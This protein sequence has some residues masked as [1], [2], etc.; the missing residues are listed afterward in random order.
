M[1][2]EIPAG[3]LSEEELRE[4][5]PQLQQITDKYKRKELIQKALFQISELASSVSELPRLYSAL[6]E[7]I[8]GFMDA[9]NFYVAFYDE[10]SDLVDI[11]YF[12][13][14][15]DELTVNEIPASQLKKGFTG[16]VLTTGEPLFLTKEN[17]E[18]K[19]RQVGA[20]D[21]GT[22]SVDWLG[23]PLKRGSKCIGAMVV[24][25][26]DESVRYSEED[27]EVLQF[28]SQHI[29][30]SVDRVK[31][32]ELTERTIRERTK[33]LRQIND[34]LQE[35]IQ[36]R[37]K[38]EDL[39]QALFEI[40]EL[41]ASVDGDME[42]FY[43]N[44]HMILARLVHAPNCYIAT[45]D[46]NK[47]MLNFP[48]FYD[49]NNASAESRPLG[50]GL[51]E[52]V[53]RHGRAELIGPVR[54]T[55]LADAGEL[56]RDVA[57]R[58]EKE[59]NYWVGTPLVVDG[60]V[61]GV[62]GIQ[63]YDDKYKYQPRDL[64]LLRYISHHIAVALERKHAQ[65]SIQAYNL[66]LA[67]KVKERTDE[68]HRANASLKEQIEERKHIELKLIHDAHHDTLTG[69]P[70]RALF[71]SRVE[72]AIANKKRYPKNKF[73]VLFIDLDRFKLINDTLGHQA[74]DK[75]LIEVS[76]RIAR[77]IR[78]HDLLARLG[79]DEFVILLDNFDNE[80]DAEEVASRILEAMSEA[81]CLDSTEMYSGG[82]IGIAFIEPWY[83]NAGELIRD[84]DAA[85]YQAKSMGRGRYVMFDQSMR[86]RL[87]EELEL[88]NEF[89]RTLKTRSFDC[90]FQPIVDM[91]T[92]KPI[93]LECYVRWQHSTLGKIKR[94]QFWRVAEHIGMTM[95]IDRFMIERACQMLRVWKDAGGEERN[96]RV[97]INL[98]INHLIQAKQVSQL[99]ERI[100]DAGIDPEKLVL[101]IDETHINRKSQQVLAA[102]QQLKEAGVTLVLDNFGNGMASLNSLCTFP[103]DYVKIDRKFVRS[104]P[105]SIENLKIIQSV[106][107]ISEHFGFE[108]IANG[109]E[110][111]EQCKALIAANC[112]FGQ[113][114]FLAEA[115]HLPVESE[116]YD[117]AEFIPASA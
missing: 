93:Y 98:S 87:L 85:M 5:V 7:I 112:R 43:A 101:E 2:T 75:F 4:L 105:A 90:Y 84:A 116:A 48:Y 66:H 67:E 36:E 117:D 109:I 9:K 13:D 47:G 22:T 59:R 97:A 28:V 102:V 62:V 64:E 81:F 18:D 110:N 49:E 40:S 46:Q 45:L 31:N 58:M 53:L 104:L 26:Y 44:L 42:N 25:S 114:K 74:G 107:Q 69:L 91:A 103:F 113:G 68:L 92:N 54:A 14:E 94:E 39:Q 51:T 38:I 77:C 70:N 15:F 60:E 82:S 30:T 6:H 23:V 108:V 111:D 8:G 37:Q 20:A 35:E 50:R 73:A 57:M 33:Q 41:S 12:V 34:E 55:E 76:K 80:E 88:E 17:Y 96:H 78:G 79:G 16:H 72:L 71:T 29:V 61:S 65:E 106:Q 24:Q 115:E 27:L 56:D 3:V 1:A 19:K 32:R 100:V 83:K 95:E 89:R 99:V 63:S 10:V 52:Y 11:V 21:L 86:E